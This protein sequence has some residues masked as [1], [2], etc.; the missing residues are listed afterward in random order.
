ME[1]NMKKSELRQIIKEEI[2]LLNEAD[3]KALRK[4]FGGYDDRVFLKK[5]WHM[6]L[7]ELNDLLKVSLLDMKWLKGNSKG[8]IG[9]FARKDAQWLKSRI[10]YIK[11]IIK[12]KTKRP[13][14]VPD[15]YIN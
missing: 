15:H 14:Y 1:N 13:D 8:T 12:S 3:I 10:D 9:L 2:H 7:D 5:V 6:S 4:E 11:Q